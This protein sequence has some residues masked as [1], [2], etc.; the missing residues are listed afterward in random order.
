[1]M[2]HID[3]PYYLPDFD[4][5][6]SSQIP[7][8]LQLINLGYTYIGRDEV[9][10]HR[11][12]N[13]QYILRDIAFNALREINGPD[14]SD[15]SI[16]EAIINL[17]KT[18]MDDGV[19][20]ASQSIFSDLLAGVGVSEFINGKKS[21]PQLR[22]IDWQNPTKNQYHVVAE[23]EISEEQNRRPDIVLF[24]NGIPFAVIENKKSSVS[25]EEA[26]K[27]MIRNQ[28][29]NQTPKFFLFPQIL[30]ATNVNELKYGTMLTPSEFYFVWKEKDAGP[31][32]E[33]SVLNR[34]NKKI[35]A[36]ILK[37]VSSDLMR[38][39]YVQ[40]VKEKVTNQDMGIYSLLR[41]ERILD[42]VRNF[43]L[44][45][46]TVKKLPRYQ[47]F[48]AVKKI[49]NTIKNKDASGKRQGGLVWHTQGSGK[50]LTM[51]MLVKNLI[52]NIQ[53]PRVIVVTD[54]I[55]LDIQIRDTFKA[56][57][58][59]VGVHQ[60]TSSNDLRKSIQSK[61][62]DVITTLIQKF[63]STPFT[64]TDN[65]IFIL[66]DEAHRSQ[67][68]DDN[69]NMNKMLPNA[70][71]IAFTGT[72][73]MTKKRRETEEKFGRLIDAYTI[74]EA[75][76]DGAIL[77][78]IYQG[79]FVEQSVN[80]VLDKFYDRVSAS[81]TEK[82]KK[83]FEKRCVSKKV[84]EETSQRI[85][86]IAADVHEHF[87]KY[88][89][90]TGLKGQ[91]VAPSKYAA[92]LFKN[93]LDM[94]GE[95]NSAV[96]ISQTNETEDEDKLPE[97]KAFVERFMAEIKRQYGSV[98]RYE[99]FVI[100]DFR[101]NPEGIELLIVVDKLLTGFD[102]PRDTV[103]YLAKQLKDHN[104]LQAIARVNRVFNG[105]E[106][107]QIKTN[108]LIIDYSK[109]AKNL[110]DALELFSNYNPD[111]IK[112]ALL[113]TDE[114][115]A[116][117]D[118][119]YQKLHS[120]F[121]DIQD[122]ENTDAY[123]QKLLSN[124]LLKNDF[125]ATVN[126]FIRTFSTCCSL[127]D[128]YDKFDTEHL[129][130]YRRDLKRFVEIKK[131]TQLVSGERVDFSKYKDQLHKLLD[132]YVTAED[133]EI[134][135]KEINLSDVRE[136]NEYID[137]EKNGLSDKSK[138]AAIAAQTSKVIQE[139]YKQDEVFYKRFSD[140]IKALLEEL[141]NAKAED[142]A[143]LFAEI[144]KVQHQVEDYEDSDIPEQIKSNRV[145]HPFYRNIKADL[146]ELP[147]TDDA[148]VVIAEHIV[149]IIR[150][151]KIVD[152]EYNITVRR[153]VLIEIEDYLLD[154]TNLGF[155]PLTAKRIAVIAWNIAVENKAM[156]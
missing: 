114:Q 110:K 47:Q 60:A 10:K 70:C 55:D 48:F 120:F 31:D 88:F 147:M 3:N 68:G 140:K 90:G 80:P 27:Q 155:S 57:N 113:N 106:G 49:L 139:R 46:K 92:V 112:G 146:S 50:S 86:M 127:Y 123:V 109:N 115:I 7:A 5:A 65:N 126:S 79:R 153:N 22:F 101:K 41:P 129:N 72:P 132:K 104:L 76:A 59:K 95:L 85:E 83:D 98:E 142:I 34:V 102:A 61:T 16:R 33:Q 96:V 53:N 52:E 119:L 89:H 156:L 105:D 8:I 32:Y 151:N 4:E 75:E 23:F 19:I 77:P 36:N 145:I 54:R 11:E 35:D 149:E 18:K 26:V 69:G 94:L 44:Y 97:H 150:G 124:E 38:E 118:S 144:K 154:E 67:G 148:L 1:M 107:R 99:K 111:D 21:S 39:Q 66:I 82:Q 20:A 135:S 130:R 103:L 71:Q 37:Q 40:S 91:L 62:T 117:L 17:E 74:S 43:T 30:V 13:G 128:F 64:D 51:V 73:L 141:K 56:C 136:F 121:A 122:K 133:V 152:F 137:N 134:L 2:Q 81:F 131:T 63:D 58:I 125:Y 28:R 138:A 45:D 100:D 143:S 42:L 29:G 12:S 108:G 9:K 87:M 25:V 116:V 93:A 6:S 84:L 14:I 78:L 15:N 24:I